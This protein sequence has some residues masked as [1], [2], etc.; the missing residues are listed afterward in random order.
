MDRH[1]NGNFLG[2]A[3]LVHRGV[4]AWMHAVGPCLSPLTA[5]PLPKSPENLPAVPGSMH[6]EL[7][8]LLSEAVLT[9]A[10]AHLS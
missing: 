2:Q 6:G 1:P 9:T 10:R 5:G 3:V 4:V 8:R 7:I